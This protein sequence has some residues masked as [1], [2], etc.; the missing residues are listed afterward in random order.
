MPGEHG[1]VYLFYTIHSSLKPVV[2]LGIHLYCVSRPVAPHAHNQVFLVDQLSPPG[3]Q[4]ELE[5]DAHIRVP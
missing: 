4:P 2:R 5:L 3:S 1:L